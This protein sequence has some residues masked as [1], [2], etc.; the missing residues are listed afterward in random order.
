MNKKT[1]QGTVLYAEIMH[2]VP[3][4]VLYESK[5]SSNP[6]ERS[7]PFPTNTIG[8]QTYKISQSIYPTSTFA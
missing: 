7:R 5:T 6:E 3:S 8:K 4:P 2:I 1:T